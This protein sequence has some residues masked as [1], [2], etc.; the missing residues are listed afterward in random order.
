MGSITT[1]DPTDICNPGLWE[2]HACGNDIT[3]CYHV[4][5]C[6]FPDIF[7]VKGSVSGGKTALSFIQNRS[8]S[9]Q[10]IITLVAVCIAADRKLNIQYVVIKG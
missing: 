2:K 10:I 8:L 7:K 3:K 9:Q 4:A 1:P 6:T 5:S